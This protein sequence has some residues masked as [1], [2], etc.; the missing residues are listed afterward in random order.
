MD[1]IDGWVA[2]M[3]FG[4]FEG[5]HLEIPQ[6]NRSYQ[7]EPGDVLFMRSALLQ[8]SVSKW[9]GDRFNCVFFSHGEYE[10]KK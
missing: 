8:H 6:V 5:A 2:D 7:V 4:T 9:K 1:T 10:V 3:A